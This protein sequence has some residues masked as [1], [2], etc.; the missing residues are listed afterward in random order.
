MKMNTSLR[1]RTDGRLN[2]RGSG[3]WKFG[4]LRLELYRET[5]KQLRKQKQP[6]LS[7]PQTVYKVTI[8]LSVPIFNSSPVVD[9]MLPKSAKIKWTCQCLGSMAIG[10]VN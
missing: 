10:Q 3:E 4:L 5:R 8:R 9:A 7:L 2:Q 6:L 1:T